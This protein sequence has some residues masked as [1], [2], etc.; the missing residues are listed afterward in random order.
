MPTDVD[1]LLE[2]CLASRAT[3]QS[4]SDCVALLDTPERGELEPLLRLSLAIR[5]AP[6]LALS[7][8]GMADGE[9]RLLARV[10]ELR[11]ARA[12]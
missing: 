9:R 4:T 2:R 10:A 1:E 3:G 12:P 6:R 11:A 8:S 5:H 7:P